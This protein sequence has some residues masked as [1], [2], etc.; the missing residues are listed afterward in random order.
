MEINRQINK[1]WMGKARTGV[2]EKSK[3]K[4]WMENVEKAWLNRNKQIN[5]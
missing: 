4:V 1:V 5:E 2:N 3:K